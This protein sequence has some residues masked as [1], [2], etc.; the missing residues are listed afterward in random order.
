MHKNKYAHEWATRAVLVFGPPAAEWATR[1]E[2]AHE[3]GTQ[4]VGG[5]QATHPHYGVLRSRPPAAAIVFLVNWKRIIPWVLL[6]FELAALVVLFGMLTLAGISAGFVWWPMPATL[7]IGI[8]FAIGCVY[9]AR[10]KKAVERG[11]LWTFAI[12]PIAYFSFFIA[13]D[14]W[15]MMNAV[16]ETWAIPAGYHGPLYV[17]RN[18][19]KGAVATQPGGGLFFALGDDGIAFVKEPHDHTWTKSTY[20]YLLKDGK[21]ITIPEGPPGSIED[22]PTNRAD[23]IRRIYFPSTGS[24]S[25][26]AGCSYEMDQAFVES[27]AEALDTKAFSEDIVEKLRLNHPGMCS[28]TLKK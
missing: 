16:R 10:K 11:I 23:T 28:T 22:T 1:A 3:W 18:V 8:V 26:A 17:I 21:T 4:L 6:A 15:Q 25:D 12:V 5:L 14:S 19:S 7:G 2:Q 24:A 20:L 27:P 9:L 13:K